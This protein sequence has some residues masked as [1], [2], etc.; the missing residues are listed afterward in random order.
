MKQ[1]NIHG[2]THFQRKALVTEAMQQQAPPNNNANEEYK[3]NP[4]PWT[5]GPLNNVIQF[6]DDNYKWR[7]EIRELKKQIEAAKFNTDER[8]HHFSLLNE[9]ALN[10]KI[11][12]EVRTEAINAV[13]KFAREEFE[14]IKRK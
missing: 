8:Q 5:T 6:N 3:G 2:C 14:E 11:P 7:E 4:E 12:E 9:L 10:R 1:F 13:I